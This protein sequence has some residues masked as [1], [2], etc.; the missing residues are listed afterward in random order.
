MGSVWMIDKGE[1]RGIYF[2]DKVDLD[3]FLNEVP[4]AAA[5]YSKQ[6]PV[7]S[8]I[9]MTHA[10]MVVRLATE[11][12]MTEF[13]MEEFRK[14]QQEKMRKASSRAIKSGLPTWTEAFM[15]D[16]PKPR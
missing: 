7:L 12:E 15:L 8:S 14:Q 16:E 5:K 6:N 10:D 4:K 9:M 11:K 3:K 1:R 13:R 2:E